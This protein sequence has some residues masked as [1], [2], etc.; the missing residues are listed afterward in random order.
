ML[1]MGVEGRIAIP[2]PRDHSLPARP[3]SGSRLRR[4]HPGG[5]DASRPRFRFTGWFQLY[6]ER[7][8]FQGVASDGNASVVTRDH[9]AEPTRSLTTSSAWPG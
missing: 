5:L 3:G 2:V 6:S 9:S 7:W 4:L 1:R 8:P